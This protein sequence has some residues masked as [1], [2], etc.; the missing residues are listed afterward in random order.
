MTRKKILEVAAWL[1]LFVE[2]EQVTELRAI[3]VREGDRAPYTLAG[4]FDG[5]HLDDMA[6]A[7]LD[8]TGRAEGV[9]FLP[10]PINPDVLARCANTARRA[11]KDELVT[12]ALILRRRWLLIDFDPC[13]IQGISSTDAEKAAAFEAATKAK[14]LLPSFGIT[15]YALADSGNGYHL[16]CNLEL[17]AADSGRV[18]RVLSACARA[19][20]SRHVKVDQKVFNPARI[21]K[22]YGTMSRK[23]DHTPSRPHRRSTI[24]ETTL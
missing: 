19:F 5:G 24:L 21:V 18:R 10:N 13:R 3:N 12:D 2:P 8:V 1:R 20:D 16:L 4:F 11:G 23:G 9:Y 7:A 22:L 17:P 14:V 6:R 15:G